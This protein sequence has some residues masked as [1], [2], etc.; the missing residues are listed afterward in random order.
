ML[1]ATFG[2]VASALGHFRD[3]TVA[4]EQ[5]CA[6]LLL[7]ETHLEHARVLVDSGRPRVEYAPLLESVRSIAQPRGA[8]FLEHG[9]DDVDDSAR[10]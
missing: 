5:A 4:H 8:A 9:C 7:A 1:A 2:D 3:A 10:G 6:P